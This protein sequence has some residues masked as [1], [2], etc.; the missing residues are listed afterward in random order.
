MDDEEKSRLKSVLI[1]SSIIIGVGA[2]IGGL[3]L[4]LNTN[5]NMLTQLT[6]ENHK[7]RNLLSRPPSV[8]EKQEQELISVES[9]YVAEQE[10]LS[11]QAIKYFDENENDDGGLVERYEQ[12]AADENTLYLSYISKK[13]IDTATK[14]R[15][16]NLSIEFHESFEAI[17]FD[18]LNPHH[19]VLVDI[20]RSRIKKTSTRRLLS[21]CDPNFV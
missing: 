12:W 1:G 3:V 19:T 4:I 10:K 2:L 13:T 16:E 6:K 7:K 15:M 5:Q 11:D 9:D 17:V 18:S 14:L 20:M 21:Q 8:R